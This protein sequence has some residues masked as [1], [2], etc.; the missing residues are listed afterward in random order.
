MF[1]HLPEIWRAYVVPAPS[2]TGLAVRQRSMSAIAQRLPERRVLRLAVLM[3][4]AV[5]SIT[6]LAV[7]DA[8]R[9]SAAALDDFAQE[10][11]KLATSLASQLRLR[12]IGVHKDATAL[13]EALAAGRPPPE[14][15]DGRTLQVEPSPGHVLPLAPG[16]VPDRFTLGL[17]V[18]KAGPFIVR[19][20]ADRVLS[21]I[22]AIEQARQLV[23]FVAMP[24]GSVLRASGAVLTP[25][26]ELA[27]AFE[28]RQTTV[29]LGSAAA[30]QLGLDERT[31]VAAL[32]RAD[33]GLLGQ[34]KVAVV[35]SA[36][37]VQ[38]RER[39]ARLREVLGILLA[40]GLVVGFG[41]VALR[42]QRLELDLEHRLAVADLE[43]E[44][45]ARLARL[46]RAATMVALAGGVAHEVS[47][48][49]GVIAGRA[50]LLETRLVGD[51]RSRRHLQSI[52]EQTDR[53]KDIVRGFLDLA[54]GGSPVLLEASAAS[55]VDGAIALVEHRFAKA[56]VYLAAET[57]RA[58]PTLRCDPR[59]LEHALVN[60]LLNACDACRPG[61][62]VEVA[63]LVA[64]GAVDFVVTDDGEG[65]SA[66]VAA[67][68]GE[69]FLT[70]K[71]SGKG[72]GLGLA[73]ATEI[74]KTHHGSLSLTPAEP[75][76]TRACLHLPLATEAERAR[77]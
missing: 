20:E 73:I 35:A 7:W 46:S 2:G 38:D 60:L 22:A 28:D 14:Y 49:L 77:A 33:A 10:Q 51:D 54:R 31:A 9:E 48:P 6:A 25:S 37:R 45:D 47:T 69:P 24:G 27:A 39:R 36:E 55:V 40:A 62:R 74:A 21:G 56:G 11:S 32:A 53:I 75:R 15:V 1:G 16:A 13:A 34:W 30:A 70:T 43:R 58:L 3:V 67:R 52:I 66:A 5:G 26:R 68:A 65:I 71:P 18:P 64:D 72:T 76:G 44:R 8:R 42:Q 23:A 29:R 17:S 41:G 57:T 63:V 19:V 61:G 50:E 4:L 59:L 12:L